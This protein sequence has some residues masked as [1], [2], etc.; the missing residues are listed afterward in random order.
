MLANDKNPEVTVSNQLMDKLTADIETA[1]GHCLN[2]G[3]NSHETE[4]KANEGLITIQEMYNSNKEYSVYLNEVDGIIL[5]LLDSTK[6]IGSVTKTI[7]DIATQTNM[8]SLN[9]AIEAARAGQAGRGFG[10]VADEIRKLADGVSTSSK[11]I[12]KTV[13]KITLDT[14]SLTDKMKIL[15]DRFVKQTEDVENTGNVFKE[16]LNGIS[17][18]STSIF[19]VS[20]SVSN[21]ER[22]INE[23]PSVKSEVA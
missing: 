2:M 12:A 14:L 8:L 6:K 19:K 20:N 23:N 11:D 7:G 5:S 17:E 10:V 13:E 3:T 1:F 18:L 21:V 22:L 16:I 4:L 15:N 9:A